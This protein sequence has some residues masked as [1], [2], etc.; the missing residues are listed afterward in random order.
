MTADGLLLAAG[1]GTRLGW[2][3]ALT[4]DRG[5]PWILRA[6]SAL[7]G[8]GCGSVTVVLG[9]E[10]DQVRT[11]L[12]AYADDPTAE[13][14]QLVEV[15]DRPV[16][17]STSL[18]LGLEALS[19]HSSAAAAAIHLVDLPDVG[20]PVVARLLAGAHRDSLV[21]ASF[22]GRPGHPAVIGADHWAALVGRL[23]GDQGAGAFLRSAG[24]CAV[25][26]ADLAT[27][28]DVDHRR[29]GLERWS[30]SIAPA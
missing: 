3:K 14:V 17:M 5:R 22:D 25:E 30:G 10:A 24:V 29:P 2:P 27:G 11:L 7:I 26:C 4:I 12:S 18:S 1:L 6:I 15:G 16:A 21:R 20:A 13:R 9:P 8:G 19:E 23:D 28:D